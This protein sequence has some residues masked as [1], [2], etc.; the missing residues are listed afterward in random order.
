MLSDEDEDGNDWG[1]SGTSTETEVEVTCPYCGEE[2]SVLV[3]SGGGDTQEYVEDCAVCCR[4]W[5]VHVSI[6]VDGAVEVWVEA[7]G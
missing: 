5:Q 6:G 3:D 1:D 2:G 7:A 4:P